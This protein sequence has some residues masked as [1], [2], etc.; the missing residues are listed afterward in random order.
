MVI[1]VVVV[2]VTVEIIVVAVVLVAVDGNYNEIFS[3]QS[4]KGS[5]RYPRR[6][7]QFSCR[8]G[9]GF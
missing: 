5:S 6:T 7:K 1:V 9:S 3:H 2:V 4:R 8:D